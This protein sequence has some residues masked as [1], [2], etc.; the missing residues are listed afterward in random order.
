MVKGAEKI[1]LAFPIEVD[2]TE[3]DTLYLRR[4]KVR[5]LK[6]MDSFSGDVEKSIQ[7]LAALCE[8]PPT[9]VEDMDTADF[10]RCSK[11]VEG[12]MQSAGKTSGTSSRG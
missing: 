5:D 10:E 9:S 11:K 12:F 1:T 2:G 3:T 8:I 4:P 7:L 6:L